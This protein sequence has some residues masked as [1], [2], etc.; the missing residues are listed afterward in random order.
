[1][2]KNMYQPYSGA[3]LPEVDQPPEI[4]HPPAPAAVINA[5]KLMYAGM[6]VN[7]IFVIVAVSIGI[8]KNTIRKDYPNLSPVNLNATVGFVVAFTIVF[9]L[10]A[11]GCWLLTARSCKKGKNWARILGSV[12]FA[13]DTL[14]ILLVI[15]GRASSTARLF[16][17]LGV[18]VADE[19][20][21]WLIGLAAIVLL[22]RRS[23]TA[24]FK[25]PPASVEADTP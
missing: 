1:M 16:N 15:A 21:V 23:S 2:R 24:F 6:A 22:W 17:H 13:L 9:G 7:A 18:L 10:V 19:T 11:I 25:A 3:R 8:S 12:L 20:V 4:H 14:R 5:V